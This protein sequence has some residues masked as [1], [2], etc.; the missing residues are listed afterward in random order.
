MEKVRIAIR[1]SSSASFIFQQAFFQINSEVSLILIGVWL[2]LFYRKRH[3]SCDKEIIQ[4]ITL[5]SSDKLR[6]NSKFCYI[7]LASSYTAQINEMFNCNK[8]ILHAPHI[9][10]LRLFS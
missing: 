2:Q 8:G 5:Y 7:E 4:S 6:P 1:S 9:L 10:N 3:G